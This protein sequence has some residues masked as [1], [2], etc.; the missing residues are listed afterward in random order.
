MNSKVKLATLY[1]YIIILIGLA[2]LVYASIN[3]QFESISGML[4]MALLSI[5]AE[6]MAIPLGKDKGISVG[7]AITLCALLTYG[8][9]GAAIV[10]AAGALFKVLYVKGKGYVH[11]FNTPFYKTAF[12]A[13]NYIISCLL[14]G[15]VYTAAGGTVLDSRFAT[16]QQNLESLAMMAFPILLLILTFIFVNSGLLSILFG[17]MTKQNIFLQ[18]LCSFKWAIPNLFAVAAIGIIILVNYHSFGAFSVLLFFGPL[19]LARYAFKLY[20]DMKN[21]YF[22]T[23]TALTAA[24]EAKDKY[25]VGHSK[26]VEGYA[27]I[28]ASEMKLTPSRMQALRYAALLHDIGKI[29]I[30]EDV[31]NK[32]SHLSKTEYDQ[33]MKHPEIGYKILEEV[34]FLKKAKEIILHHHEKFD[35][36]GY[37][38]HLDGAEIPLESSIMAVADAFDAMTSDRPY[39]KALSK[40]EAIDELLKNSGKQFNPEVVDIFIN[41][42]KKYDDSLEKVS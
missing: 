29:G 37:P 14:A 1:V 16:I 10:S 21:V 18:W 33:I 15:W 38:H 39:R 28:I 23:I 9:L 41:A 25:T 7:F 13:A 19:L 12:N 3:T 42:L 22:E 8:P 24:I 32:N 27:S 30:S 35:G 31:L 20:I 5:T 11:I 6:S 26:R 36:S 2:L 17:L 4:F 40:N 34:D